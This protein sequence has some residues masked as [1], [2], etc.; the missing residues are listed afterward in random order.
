MRFLIAIAR[1]I[2]G[3]SALLL[4]WARRKPSTAAE[5]AAADARE[6]VARHDEAAV[7][8][9][10]ESARLRREARKSGSVTIPILPIILAVILLLL[11]TVFGCVRVRTR[12]LVIPAD[13]KT[14]HIVHDG[15]PGWFVPDATMA[16]IVE[17]YVLDSMKTERN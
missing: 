1:A 3:I 14:V 9:A 16:D 10:I 4:L 8:S 13:R 11:A 7:N 15:I 12:T 17:S 5:Q 6:A 2:A